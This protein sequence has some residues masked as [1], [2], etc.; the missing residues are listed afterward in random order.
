MLWFGQ[1][2]ISCLDGYNPV[3]TGLFVGHPFPIL[4]TIRNI[5]LQ[6]NDITLTHQMTPHHQVRF[7]PISW[8]PRPLTLWSR[9]A[10]PVPSQATP[11]TY[12]G[13]WSYQHSHIPCTVIQPCFHIWCFLCLECQP[14]KPLSAFQTPTYSASPCLKYLLLGDNFSDPPR[15]ELLSS[16]SVFCSSF[17]IQLLNH[18]SHCNA[19]PCPPDNELFKG[20]DVCVSSYIHLSNHSRA[21]DKQ[22]T[23]IQVFTELIIK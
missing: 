18:L 12:P 23:L 16:S 7:K 20:K 13:P 11:S 6:S 3:L 21:R 17:N 5:F 15:A 22:D 4:L 10:S 2:L 9:Y 19:I 14:A 1:D 8:H